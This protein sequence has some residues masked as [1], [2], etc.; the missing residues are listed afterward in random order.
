MRTNVLNTLNEAINA[1]RVQG[2]YQLVTEDDFYDGRHVTIK[3]QKLI[4]FGNCS[5]LGLEVDDRLKQGAIDAIQKFGIQFSSSRFYLACTLYSELETLI[6][7]IFNAPVALSTSVSLGHHGVIPVVINDNDAI[8]LDQQVH[9]SVQDAALKMQ[10]KGVKVTIVR[11]NDMNELRQKIEELSIQYDKVWYLM[12]GVYSM[13]GDFAPMDTIVEFLNCYKKFH[14]YAD[15]AHGM[16][17]CGKNGKGYILSKTDLHPKMIIATSLNKAFASGG[18]A[19]IFSDE[20]LCQRVKNCGG[21]FMFSGPHQI[22]VLGAAIASA[23]IHLSDEIYFRQEALQQ[24]ISY[25]HK[26]LKAYDLPVISA[27]ETPIFFVG[28]GLLRVGQ[29]MVKKMLDNGFYVNISAFPAVPESCTGIRFTIT[30][31]HTFE[32]IKR[33]VD[34]IAVNFRMVLL[35]EERSIQDIHRAFRRIVTFSSSPKTFHQKDSIQNNNFVISHYRSIHQ[36]PKG[37]WNTLMQGKGNFDWE[38]LQL[39]EKVFSHNPEPENNW[40]FHYYVVRNIEG[41]PILATFFTVTLTKDD[42]LAPLSVSDQL[43]KARIKNKYYLTSKTMMMGSLITEGDHLFI[44]KS[45]PD[46]KKALMALVDE[47]WKQQDKHK[48]GSLLFRDFNHTDKEICEFFKEQGFITYDMPD[49]HCIEDNQWN[50]LDHY[51]SLFKHEKR[52]YLRKRVFDYEDKFNVKISSKPSAQELETLYNLYLNI[53]KKNVEINVFPLPKK[54]FMKMAE[55]GAYEF[56]SLFIKGEKE[57]AI[58]MA[59]N[60]SSNGS[61]HFLFTGM[62]YSLSEKYNIYPQLLWQIV[63]RANEL[64]V[65]VVHLGFTAGQ[66]KRKFGARSISKVAFIQMKDNFN[67]HLMEIMQKAVVGIK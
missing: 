13:Y 58:G 28:M 18:G 32:D 21:S 24:R 38:A 34:A 22:P 44:D 9:S 10:A 16:S 64:N 48:A 50:N 15:D 27:S 59:I 36:V 66:N 47:C 37:F 6:Q 14:I 46:W 40:K 26:L 33:L 25:C 19:F 30:L 57:D 20:D 2:I 60:Y 1:S 5:Y 53:S 3:G 52:Y 43:E 56:I 29:N 62:D 51:L 55:S 12:D 17:W 39:I 8:I 23:K 45:F 41:K 42:M 49:T 31:H 11:H 7:K 65:K 63:K 61:Y 54:L 4:N 35:E 67:M